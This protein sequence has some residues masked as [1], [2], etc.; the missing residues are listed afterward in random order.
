M[1]LP[2]PALLRTRGLAAAT[3]CSLLAASDR[4]SYRSAVRDSLAA[5]L[6]LQQ[7]AIGERKLRN[8]VIP[9]PAPVRLWAC[10]VVTGDSL[11]LSVPSKRRQTA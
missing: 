10:N 5:D 11:P 3:V 8:G 2:A 6:R 4:P 7:P 1:P 9:L